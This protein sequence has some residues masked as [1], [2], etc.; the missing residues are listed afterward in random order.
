MSILGKP[1]SRAIDVLVPIYAVNT[2]GG[3]YYSLGTSTSAPVMSVNV[4]SLAIS[5]F[6][7]YSQ[8]VR[9]YGLIQLKGCQLSIYRSSNLVMN[10]ANITNIPSLNL[11]LSQTNYS[12]GTVTLQQ[13]LATSDNSVEIN[14]NTFDSFSF[15][16]NFPPNVVGRSALLGTTFSYGSA[17][18]SPTI[19]NGSQTLPDIYLNLG[20]FQVPSFT[21]T[22]AYQA[23]QIASVHA[24]L[25]V[26]FAGPQS[27]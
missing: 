15:N 21:N 12:A 11:Q 3:A 22:P 27:F 7:E 18:W 17:V 19:I 5:T 25:N 10:T 13:A 4:P 1:V 6:P 23:Y 26:I 14:L 16:L 2:I 24:R 20:S 8:L 9:N